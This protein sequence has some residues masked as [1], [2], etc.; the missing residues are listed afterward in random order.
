MLI[1]L[2]LQGFHSRILSR[3]QRK[4]I[5]HEKAVLEAMH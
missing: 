4:Y 2:K 5:N 1:Q 3:I